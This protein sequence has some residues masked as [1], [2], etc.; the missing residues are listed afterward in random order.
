MATKFETQLAITRLIWEK[1]Y[2]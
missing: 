2:M 1:I